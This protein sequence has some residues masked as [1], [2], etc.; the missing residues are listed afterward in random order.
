MTPKIF[1]FFLS[2]FFCKL[3][4]Y[5]IVFIHLG[6][7]IPPYLPTALKQARLFNPT[8][9]IY[10]IKNKNT[11]SAIL[12][13]LRIIP[14]DCESLPTSPYHDT[15]RKTTK[16]DRG[17][18]NGFW[19]YTSERFYYLH[20]LI[21][22]YQLTDVFHLENDVMLYADLSELL[23]VFQLRYKGMI[24]ATYEGVERCVPGFL[25]ISDEKP[26]HALIQFI[27]GRSKLN[28]TDMDSVGRFINYQHKVY[29]DTLPVIFPNYSLLYSFRFP[30]PDNRFSNHFEAFD[31]LFDAAAFGQYL[32]GDSPVHSV[33]VP[34][35]VNLLSVYDS[36]HFSVDWELDSKG[37]KIPFLNL[38]GQRKRLNNLHIHSKT[39]QMFDSMQRNIDILTNWPLSDMEI[40]I[41][42]GFIREFSSGVD[43]YRYSSVIDKV[44]V[45]NPFLSPDLLAPIPKEKRILFTWEPDGADAQYCDAFERIYTFNDDLIDGVK[46][47]KYCY[48]SLHPMDSDLPSFQERKLCTMI[49]ANWKPERIAVVRLFERKLPRDFEFYGQRTFQM[50]HP[51]YKGKIPGSV[52]FGK[53]KINTLKKYRFCICFENS[54]IN[55]YITEKIFGCFTAGCVPVYLGAP[56]I[57]KYIPKRCFIDYCDFQSNDDLYRY[58]KSMPEETYL[59]YLENIREFLQSEQAQQFSLNSFYQLFSESN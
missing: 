24:G 26:I 40:E 52:H 49:V 30:V 39:L 1:L 23:H 44:V 31:S 16:L 2:V 8:C 46:Y 7:E 57:E 21:N 25:Y 42:Y 38:G 6:D 47:F 48:P 51:L 50:G 11:L 29:I 5:S 43:S 54:R 9:D 12:E 10:L 58:L 41:P 17:S 4:P 13:E 33:P 56:N 36:S 28:E 22:T 18:L 27:S 19:F 34:G 32:G 55:G 53:G 14:I 35:F 45:M 59:Q 37:R 3:F 15:F 20:E